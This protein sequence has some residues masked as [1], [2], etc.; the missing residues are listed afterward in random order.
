M[1]ADRQNNS[2]ADD[3]PREMYASQLDAGVSPSDIIEACMRG[4]QNA[5]PGEVRLGLD[6]G[7][8]L[9]EFLDTG[10]DGEVLVEVCSLAIAKVEGRHRLVTMLLVNTRPCES[11]RS[12][13]MHCDAVE[14]LNRDP[15][16]PVR[17]DVA[18]RVYEDSEGHFL[19]F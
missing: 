11:P 1:S 17:G 18:R 6:E 2:A 16:P 8:P 7:R 9:I 19:S 10:P 3:A 5:W 4:A 13:A 15:A 14:R 12:S